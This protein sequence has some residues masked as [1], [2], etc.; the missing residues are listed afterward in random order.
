MQNHKS[1]NSKSKKMPN[2]KENAIPPLQVMEQWEIDLWRAHTG[3]WTSHYTVRNASGEILDE[4]DAVPFSSR[5]S[6]TSAGHAEPAI[7]IAPSSPMEF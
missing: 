5:S 6:D 7:A 2:S 1:D 4:Y 3:T